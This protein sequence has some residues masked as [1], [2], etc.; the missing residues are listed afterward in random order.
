MKLNFFG[1][2]TGLKDMHTSAYFETKDKKIV[3]IDCPFSSFYKM[4][5]LDLKKI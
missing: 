4:K 3:I 5:R 2:E 1:I